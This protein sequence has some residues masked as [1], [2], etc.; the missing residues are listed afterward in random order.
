MLVTMLDDRGI[1]VSKGSACASGASTP[2]RVLTS[3]GMD[4]KDAL[5][6][7]R[8]SLSSKNTEEELVEAVNIISECIK[9]LRSFS[10]KD[11]VSI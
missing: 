9:T 3:M 1:C 4:Q 8:I 10:K 7:I 2:S 11:S 5:S 6:T